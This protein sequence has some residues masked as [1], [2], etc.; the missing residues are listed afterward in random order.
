MNDENNGVYRELQKHLDTMPVG[1]PA[2]DSG[3][4]IKILKHLF[5]PEQAKIALK[6]SFMADPLKRIH[7]KLK[8]D[9]SME[10]LEKKLDEMYFAG[11][12]HR[13]LVK[14]GETETKYYGAAPVVIG[15]FEYQLKRLTP[16][17][18]KMAHDYIESTFFREEY[19]ST[20]IPQLL[21]VRIE[22]TVDQEQSIAQYDD[23]RTL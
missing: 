11:L 21:R 19:N 7:R 14:E 9:Y 8:N 10:D 5:S 16:E 20:G 22:E 2:T 12:I 1:Y 15:F 6:L 13:G 4:E 17:F 18:Y 3:I 23:L